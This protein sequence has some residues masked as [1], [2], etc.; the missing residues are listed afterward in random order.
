MK[1]LKKL[2][3]VNIFFYLSDWNVF[4]LPCVLEEKNKLVVF[5]TGLLHRATVCSGSR[6][7]EVGD[8]ISSIALSVEC[9]QGLSHASLLVLTFCSKHLI[10]IKRMYNGPSSYLKYHFEY[11]FM[12]VSFAAYIIF[13]SW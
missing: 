4:F 1:S 10:T 5:Y 8:S 2:L 11:I 9:Y 6:G 3:G 7:Q 12:H 13:I